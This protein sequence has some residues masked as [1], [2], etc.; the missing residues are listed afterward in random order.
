MTEP[1][2]I[3]L[4]L[5]TTA[6]ILQIVALYFSIVSV[7]IGALHYFLSRAPWLMRLVAFV[8]FSGAMVFLGITTVAV[9]RTTSGVL[10]ALRQLPDR[11][12]APPP[13]ELYFGLDRFVTAGDISI[14]VLAGWAMTL[15]IYLA[16]A[17]LTFAYKAPEAKD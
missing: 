5:D 14:G 6:S 8:F 7:Y 11:G 2:L 9:E 10:N 4:S 12:A 1:E 13:T 3:G 17:Y 16:L 15:G